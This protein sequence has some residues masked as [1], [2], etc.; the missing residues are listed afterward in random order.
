MSSDGDENPLAYFTTV[1]LIA[2]L[3]M[4][5]D[6]AVFIGMKVTSGTEAIGQYSVM[7][8]W[9]G[10]SHTAAGMALDVANTI[11]ANV[12]DEGTQHDPDDNDVH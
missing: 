7:R 9:R 1:D 10:N 11:I 4:R 3:M 5:H 8:R 12:H 2:E 6:H